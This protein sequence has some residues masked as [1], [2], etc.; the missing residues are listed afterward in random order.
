MK[1]LLVN[2]LGYMA[3]GAETVFWSIAGG[4]KERG[5]EVRTLSS[6][7]PSPGSANNEELITDYQVEAVGRIR[8]MLGAWSAP[9]A[10]QFREI[11]GEYRPDVIHIHNFFYNLSPSIL[12]ETKGYK[13]FVH[14]HDYSPI[15]ARDKV[16]SPAVVCQ[17][18]F[19]SPKCLISCC[20]KQGLFYGVIRRLAAVRLLKGKKLIAP[21]K[22]VAEAFRREGLGDISVLYNPVEVPPEEGSPRAMPE[23]PTFVFVGRL[24]SQKGVEILLDALMF[25]NTTTSGRGIRAIIAGDGPLR[26]SLEAKVRE[27]V[28]DEQI[29][30]AGKLSAGEVTEL[31]KKATAVV[32]PSIWPE[33]GPLVISEA[34]VVG[35][36]AVGSRI[37]AIVEHID[38]EETGMLFEVGKGGELGH[39][40]MELARDP[41]KA[42]RLGEKARKK[43]SER[44]EGQYLDRIV[45]MYRS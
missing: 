11:L 44:G 14:L 23:V 34:A 8:G 18:S 29:T 21:S 43:H 3:G 39:K 13:T 5:Y 9:A 16:S 40:L 31:Y 6:D 26:E 33:I 42:Q 10:R 19:T 38:D 20:F 4:L 17:K 36:T 41:D 2:D 30:F 25:L 15:C 12:A 24:A 35:C 45:E 22:F 7:R 1:V 37:G 32:T 27:Y 28:H